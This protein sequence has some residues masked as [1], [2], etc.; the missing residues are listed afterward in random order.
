M[1]KLAYY[2]AISKYAEDVS[3]LDEFGRAILGSVSALDIGLRKKR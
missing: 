3:A 1:N 2:Q